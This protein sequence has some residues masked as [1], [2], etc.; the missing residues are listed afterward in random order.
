MKCWICGNE[1]ENT[2]GGC[3]RCK[4]CGVGINDL[5]FRTKEQSD[6]KSNFEVK[7]Q[8]YN[9]GWVCPKCGGVMAPNQYYCINCQPKNTQATSTGITPTISAENKS[10][11]KG[12]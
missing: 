9:Q 6:T 5:V 7:D 2:I 10:I 8:F 12:E 1:M 3:Y 4:D 11:S